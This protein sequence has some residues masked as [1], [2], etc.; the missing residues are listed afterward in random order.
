MAKCKSESI[1]VYDVPLIKMYEDVEVPEY[2][3]LG[4][5]GADVRAYSFSYPDDLG[6]TTFISDDSP[7]VM[8]PG[9]RV[10]VRTGIKVELP[11]GKEIQVRPRSGL[12]LKHGVTVLNS[13]GTI[14]ASYRGEIGIILLNTSNEEFV[15]N[16][17]DR[18]AQLVLADVIQAYY[19]A[20][21]EISDSDRGEKGFG[22]SGVK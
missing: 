8:S 17:Q 16:K 5:S 20:T 18:V 7:L 22:D 10:L 14:D 19:K 15:I 4:C 13:P 11:L 12:A 1:N 3:D 2:I 6:T 21:D 9:E